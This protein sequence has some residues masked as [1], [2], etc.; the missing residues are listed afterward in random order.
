[1]TT[2]VKSGQRLGVGAELTGVSVKRAGTDTWNWICAKCGIERPVDTPRFWHDA[3]GAYK[4]CRKC[5]AR[6]RF[7]AVVLKIIEPLRRFFR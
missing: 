6:A 3:G 7:A 5:A 4:L 1:M 2:E